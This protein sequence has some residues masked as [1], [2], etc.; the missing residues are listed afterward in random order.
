MKYISFTIFLISFL[1]GIVY[2]CLSKPEMK[3]VY[4]NPNPDN[5]NTNI[6]QD[7]SENCF[8]YVA[9]EVNCES[10]EVSEFP[11]QK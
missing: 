10:Q 8:Q 7:N 1:V 3:V 5:C 9:E 11:I 6:Y 2:V 4:I